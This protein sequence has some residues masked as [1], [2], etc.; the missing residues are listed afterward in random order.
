MV[1]AA[2]T[3]RLIAP[4][5]FA[6]YGV[7][8]AVGALTL[9]LAHGGLGQV[10]G[11]MEETTPQR[12]RSLACY[13]LILGLLGAILLYLTAGFW[14]GI[15]GTAAAKDPIRV[16]SVA[17]MIAP[18]LGLSAGLLRRQGRFR[19]LSIST[20]ACTCL[21]M[22]LGLIAV[23]TWRTSSS[24]LIASIVGQFLTLVLCAG[25]NI[26]LLFGAFLLRRSAADLVFSWKITATSLLSYCNG[27]IGK[28]AVSN[29]LPPGSL[30][31]WNRADVITTVPF[32]QI[33]NAVIQTVYPEFRH[34]LKSGKRA[35]VVWVDLLTVVA[36]VVLPTAAVC[37]AVVPYVATFLFGPGW[38]DAVRLT[39]I[40]AIVGGIQIV[41]T[42]LASAVEALGRFRLIWFTNGML[43]VIYSSAA[44][45]CISTQEWY[46]ITGGLLVGQLAQH[47]IHVFACGRAGYLDVPVLLLRYA[48]ITV[49]AGLLGLAAWLS[50]Q[51][52]VDAAS[53]L[54]S[55]AVGTLAVAGIA[56]LWHYRARL[57]PYRILRTYRGR[58]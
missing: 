40:L 53:P 13:A 27:N 16:M 2:I 15:W 49:I 7:A 45:A 3:S 34:D 28:L 50:L 12:I 1:Y 35:K 42:V 58:G 37:S 36:W 22:C 51:A 29:F 31:H 38:E 9:L 47:T 52:I 24:L 4:D 41:S 44:V 25:A 21:G 20:F 5:G 48:R 30:G 46:P 8:L 56:T 26:R 33:Q 11:R 23:F 14:A 54:L 6:A 19:F 39:W 55:T 32:M 17:V 57:E 10:I 18:I 43:F